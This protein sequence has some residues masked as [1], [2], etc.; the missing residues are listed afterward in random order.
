MALLKGLLVADWGEDFLVS[1]IDEYG[2][3]ADWS[4]VTHYELAERLNTA[5]FSA[6]DAPLCWLPEV[7]RIVCGETGNPL[8]DTS[9]Y[10]D[11]EV[12]HYSWDQADQV[13]E[14]WQ[15]AKPEVEKLREFSTWCTGPAEMQA[16]IN[17]LVGQ[18]ERKR[19]RRG[20]KRLKTLE[21]ILTPTRHRMRVTV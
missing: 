7:A 15:Q 18:G 1:L 10:M 16:V 2:L 12:T 4:G 9:N 19:K 17:A 5:D 8:L 6:Y 11:D 14:L 13:R 3:E 20:N 21:N